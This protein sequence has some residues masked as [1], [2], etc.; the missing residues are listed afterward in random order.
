[1]I[2]VLSLFLLCLLFTACVEDVNPNFREEV[3]APEFYHRAVK[4]LTDVIVHDIFSPPQAGRIYA[5]AGIAGYEAMAAGDSA[6]TSLA[7]QIPHLTAIP[8]PPAGT[9]IAYPVA[10]V[11]AQLKVGK[12]LTFSEEKITAF[13]DIIFADLAAIKMPAATLKASIAYGHQIADHIIA[14]TKTDNY[15]QSRTF[16]KYAITSDPS[17]WQPTPPDYMDGIEPSWATIRSFALDRPDQFKPLA[18]TTYSEDPASAWWAEAV[19]VHEAL[20]SKDAD[21]LAEREAIAKFWDC[22]PY[23]SHHTGHVVFATKKITPGGHWVNITAIAARQAK[24][25]LATTTLAY[26][27]VGM[28]IHDG[29]ISCWDEKYRSNLVRPE[30]FINN[31]IDEDWRPLLQTPP[32]PEHTSGHS[33]VSRACAVVLTE[34]FGDNFAFVDDSEVEY[35]LPERSYTGFLQASEEAALSRLYG[36]IHYRPAITYGISQG[37]AVGKHLLSRVSSKPTLTKK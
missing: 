7:G 37:E 18:P 23:V 19:E 21:D 14:W 4:Q 26:A 11:A 34:L 13:E 15:L 32:F 25:D 31:H 22:N 24:A 3:A 10:A 17:K 36:G 2:R 5:Y 28:A 27:L 29:F 6:L 30:T 20:T 35:E 16:P 33:V 1:M 12:A 9:E 8:A